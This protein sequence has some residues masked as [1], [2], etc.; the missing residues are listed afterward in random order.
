[1][2]PGMKETYFNFRESFSRFYELL[3]LNEIE[4]NYGKNKKKMVE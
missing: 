1:M 2:P 4:N 3:R